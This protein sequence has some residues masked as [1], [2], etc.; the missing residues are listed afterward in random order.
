[1]SDAQPKTKHNRYLIPGLRRGLAILSLFNRN[2]IEIGAPEIAKE[3]SI[4]RST[5]FRLLATLEY[6]GFL[7][8]AKNGHDYRLGVAVLKLG[9]EYLGALEITELAQ[10]VLERLRDDTGFTAH[11]AIRSGQEVVFVLKAIA[12]AALVSSVAIGTRLPAHATVLGRVFLADLSDVEMRELYPFEKLESF[13]SQTPKTVDELIGLVRS[14][15]ARGY[16]ISEA[17]FE[18]G[19]CAIAAPV[20]D[21][22]G[23]VVAAI[24]IIIPEMSADKKELHGSLAHR[25][26]AAAQELSFYLDYNPAPESGRLAGKQV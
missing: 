20:R 13:S 17:F 21:A 4:P 11:L 12:N 25:V 26:T 3:L 14:D 10:P 6:L 16:A 7:E 2:R 5:V 9:F 19:I 8:R 23:R 24:N 1:M 22:S 18:R 15:G